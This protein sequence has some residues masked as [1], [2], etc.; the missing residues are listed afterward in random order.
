MQLFE[1]CVITQNVVRIKTLVAGV[2]SAGRR[3]QQRL[4]RRQRQFQD[5]AQNLDS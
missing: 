5:V 4:D 1:N 2:L 3:V